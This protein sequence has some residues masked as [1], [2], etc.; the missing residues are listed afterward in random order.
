MGREVEIKIAEALDVRLEPGLPAAIDFAANAADPRHL[1]LRRGWFAATA[2]PGAATLVAS[3]ADGSVVAALPTTATGPPSLGLRAVPGS[4]WPFR[5]FPISRDASDSELEAL[6]S[7]PAARRAL[8]RWWRLGPIMAEDPTLLRLRRVAGACGFSVLA[9]LAGTDF[10]LDIAML[11]KSESWPRASTQRNINKHRKRL[12]RLGEVEY[13]YVTGKDWSPAVFDALARIERHSWIGTKHGAD[14]KFLD[15]RR[16]RGWETMIADPALAEMLGVGILSIGGEPVAFSFGLNCGAIRYCVATSYDARFAKHSP[17]YL[18]GYLTYIEAVE[19]RVDLLS[20]GAGDG[21]EKGSMGAV[22]NGTLV[23][24]L[25]VRGK[26][27][28]RLI[29]PWWRRSGRPDD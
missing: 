14:A 21:G 10:A 20:L 22:P 24:C 13:R 15:A 19:R 2:D 12:G 18:A 26:L 3:R 4:Y 27:L 28:A 11:R 23:D 9:R 5:S 1:F 8:G 7:A 17:G 25:F 29:A 16:R 6:L